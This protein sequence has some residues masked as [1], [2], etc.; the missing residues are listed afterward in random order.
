MPRR[1]GQ[2]PPVVRKRRSEWKRWKKVKEK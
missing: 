1:R 2:S